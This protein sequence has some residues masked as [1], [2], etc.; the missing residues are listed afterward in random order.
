MFIVV[1]NVSE[2]KDQLFKLRKVV[3]ERQSNGVSTY[4]VDGEGYS[5]AQLIGLANSVVANGL[6]IQ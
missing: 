3:T 5:A 6:A 1:G 2:A 4:V